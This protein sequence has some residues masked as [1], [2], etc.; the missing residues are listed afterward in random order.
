[1]HGEKQNFTVDFEL[2][3]RYITE[4]QKEELVEEI[5]SKKNLSDQDLNSDTITE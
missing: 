2:G 3:D 5:P 1:M 4:T